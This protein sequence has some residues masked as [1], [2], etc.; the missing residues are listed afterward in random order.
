MGQTVKPRELVVVDA[1]DVSQEDQIL[2]L[3][4]GSGIELKYVTGVP[5][6]T[7]QLNQGIGLCE[8]D[9]VCILDDD[10]ELDARWHQAILECFEAGG[11]Q[12]GGVQG[13]IDNL[14]L[15]G[16][17][18]RFFRGLFFLRRTTTNS[19]GRL[20]P[21]G[22]FT[23]PVAPSRITET[24][25]LVSTA[26]A[27]RRQILSEYEFDEHLDGYAH[28]EDIDFSY[29]VGRRYSLAITPH[30]RLV[31]LTTPHSRIAARNWMRMHV[32]NNHY[33]FYKNLGSSPARRLAFWWS[34]IGRL[35]L[36]AIKTAVRRDPAFLMGTLDGLKDVLRPDHSVPATAKM[37]DD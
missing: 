13:V 33:L 24:E 20:L 36:A 37:G 3:L 2:A 27:Y 19:P 11:P 5:G 23:M 17:W 4:E 28:K 9:P 8:G 30:A 10:V 15:Y 31:H 12:L 32:V 21:S 26:V 18:A 25:V 35:L 34:M 6:R 7:R 29:R 14:P 1:S 22:Y 16:L